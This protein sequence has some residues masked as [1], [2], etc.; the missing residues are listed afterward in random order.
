[1]TPKAENVNA[2]QIMKNKRPCWNCNLAHPLKSCPAYND[3]CKACGN[4]GHWQIC[5][6]KTQQ[7][8]QHGTGQRNNKPRQRHLRNNQRTSPEPKHTKSA[9]GQQHSNRNDREHRI[10]DIDLSES[11]SSTQEPEQRYTETFY[12][13]VTNIGSIENEAFTTVFTKF[14]DSNVEGPLRV[15]LD[16]GSDGNRL[17]LRIFRQVFGVAKLEDMLTPEPHVTL[18]AYSGDTIPCLGYIR[19]LIKRKHGAP[20]QDTKFY[21]VDVSGS[22]VLGLP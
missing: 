18:K 4:L 17:P 13:I 22:A 10:D 8:N 6:R 3:T 11:E 12:S 14:K 21:I 7:F 15:K 1:M 19:L 9:Y 16:T 2:V 5:C 20:Y